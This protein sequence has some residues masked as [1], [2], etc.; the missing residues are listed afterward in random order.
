MNFRKPGFV[1]TLHVV[2]TCNRCGSLNRKRRTEDGYMW[3][4]ERNLFVKPEFPACGV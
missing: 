3:C 1:D 2:L 4:T